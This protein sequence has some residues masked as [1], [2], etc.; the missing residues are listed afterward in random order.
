MLESPIK[1]P[2]P[3]TFLVPGFLSRRPGFEPSAVIVEFLEEQIV[4]AQPGR[5]ADP[6]PP[7]NTEV[8]KRLERYV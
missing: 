7:S 1:R 6:T 2:L 8:K 5:D 4:T 3:F